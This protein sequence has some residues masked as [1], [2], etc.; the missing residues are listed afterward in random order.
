LQ[1]RVDSLT[2]ELA[3]ARRLASLKDVRAVDVDLARAELNEALSSAARAAANTTPVRF[4][5]ADG[6]IVKIHA[7]RAA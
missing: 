7:G 6:R 3:A 1:L 2:H 5:P 4:T